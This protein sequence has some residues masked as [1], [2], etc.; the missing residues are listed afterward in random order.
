MDEDDRQTQDQ[1][2]GEPDELTRKVEERARELDRQAGPGKRLEV[3]VERRGKW[4][5]LKGW[6]NSL[7][8]KSRLLARVPRIHGAQWVIDRL[9]VRKKQR[10]EK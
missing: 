1:R 4:F 5:V 9:R 10:P 7:K 2:A 6:V 8:L 3:E